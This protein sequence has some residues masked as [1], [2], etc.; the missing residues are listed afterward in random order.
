MVNVDKAI[1]ARLKKQGHNFEILVDCDNAVAFKEGKPV[2]M[3]DVLA[4]TKIFSDS[5]K[6]FVAQESSLKS[7][8]GT[9]DAL[10][11]AKIIIKEGEIQ[12]TAEHRAKLKEQKTKRILNY[13][14]RNGVD[15]RTNLPHPL[16]RLELA[17]EEAKI[18]ID[19]NKNEEKQIDEIIKKLKPILPIYF[20]TSEIGVK[21][22]ANIAGN[23]HSKVFNAV[24]SF[25]KILKNEWLT[26]GSWMCVVEIP[27]GLQN[28][29]FDKINSVTHGNAEMKVLKQ[30]STR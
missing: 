24:S 10:D 27:A 21:I 17:F 20:A 28:D 29:L 3:K 13:L 8:F 15:P 18:R 19:E 11:I 14:H 26:D 2:D 12:L 1:I 6:G 30:N 16:Q 22:P 7:L 23:T 5:K 4:D 9:S 25:G